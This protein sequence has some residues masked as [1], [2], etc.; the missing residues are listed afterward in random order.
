M[1]TQPLGVKSVGAAGRISWLAMIIIMLAQFQ[2]AFNVNALP[3]SVGAISEQFNAPATSVGTALVV[4]SLFVAAFVLLGSKLGK[5]IGARLVFQ[6]T[7]LAHGLAMGLMA[8]SSDV[9]TMNNAQAIAGL[10]A[11]ALVPTLVVLIAGNYQGKQQEQALGLLAGTPAISGALAFFVAGFLTTTVSWRVSFGLLAVLSVIIF[12]LSFRLARIPR[13][14]EVKIDLVGAVLA[15]VAIILISV[16]FNNLNNWGVVLANSNAPFSLFGLSPAPFMV[17]AGLVVGQGFLAWS[18]YRHDKGKSPLLSLEVFDSQYERAALYVLLVISGLGPAVNFLIPLYIQIVQG[19]T[20]LF[21]AVAV[22]PYTLAIATAAIFIVRLY[23]RLSPRV[24][25]AGG[26]ITVSVGLTMLAFTI[27]NEWGTP[28]VILSLII[29]G[30]GEGSLLTLVFNVLVAASPP[31][32]AGDVGAIRGV[33]NNLSTAL[34][35][36]FAS[37]AAVTLLTLFVGGS[38]AGNTVIPP[39]LQQQV[40]LD[41]I[42]FVSNEQLKAIL[43][44]TSATPEQVDAAVLINT[45]AR[46]RALKAAFLILAAIA[47]LGVFPALRLPRTTASRGEQRA[48]DVDQDVGTPLPSSPAITS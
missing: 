18:H 2:M 8:I 30:L 27:R 21:T 4:Y 16:G 5:L 7:V 34:G 42:N 17:L 13:D 31:S 22:V 23:D 45:L 20:S 37:L 29:V 24:I 41:N 3:V 6:V 38:L 46:L 32:L 15:A 11:A 12:L 47:L 39:S 28:V 36:A 33:A 14:A 1:T 44:T 35:T 19:R 48:P 9:S 25:G 40:N 26:L 43:S 10:A